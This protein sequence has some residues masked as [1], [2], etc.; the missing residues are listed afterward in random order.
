VFRVHQSS[1]SASSGNVKS[2][3]AEAAGGDLATMAQSLPTSEHGKRKSLSSDNFVDQETN[4]ADRQ[5]DMAENVPKRVKVVIQDHDEMA[6]TTPSIEDL[7][8]KNEIL[9]QQLG[10]ARE[11][12]DRCREEREK[13]REKMLGIMEELA[14]R[15]K[16]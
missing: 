9:Q 3:G 14:K 2:I 1:H 6:H 15:G 11:D 12:L 5:D 13:E 16:E 4:E 8:K 10:K 7:I